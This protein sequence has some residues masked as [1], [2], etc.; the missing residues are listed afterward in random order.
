MKQGTC[1]YSNTGE[2]STITRELVSRW[3]KALE[4]N[5]NS[6]VFRDFISRSRVPNE[7]ELYG[8]FVKSLLEST[9]NTI[10]HIAT[11]FQIERCEGE[12]S[13]GSKG[14]VDLLF[15]YR[16][17]SYLV[18]L[19]VG[20]VNARGEDREPKL[21]A[22]EIWQSAIRQLDELK[23]DSVNGLLQKKIV[24]LSI[25]LYFFDSTKEIDENEINYAQLHGS[26]FDF[27]KCDDA[28]KEVMEFSPHFHQFSL[29][30]RIDTRLRRTDVDSPYCNYIYGF[31]MFGRQML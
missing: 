16:S 9:D 28:G 15:D 19:K 14:R 27:I 5:M 10:G 2:G 22:R 6:D 12:T 1:Y 20:R 29:T 13:D 26:V 23:V 3:F 24:K 31:G 8:V 17:A 21:R 30:P 7:R 4:L 11:E 18:E 25:A